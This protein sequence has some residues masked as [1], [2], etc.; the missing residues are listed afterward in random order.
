[1]RGHVRAKGASR[2]VDGNFFTIKKPVLQ[3]RCSNCEM[4]WVIDA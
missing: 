3:L 1:M 4:K 2:R